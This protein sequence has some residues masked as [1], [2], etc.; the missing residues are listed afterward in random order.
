MSRVVK[1]TLN[2]LARRGEDLN[3]SE[4]ERQIKA[5]VENNNLELVEVNVKKSANSILEVII[6]NKDG[7]TLDDCSN[8]SREIDKNIT[9]DDY[10]Q[11]NY[12]IEV[13]SPGLDRNLKTDD[14]LRRNQDK[15]LELK[16]YSKVNGEKEFIG[17][18]K[19]YDN[20]KLIFIVEDE[21]IEIS[22][23]NISTLKQYIDFGGY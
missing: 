21:E 20:E 14:D 6:Y 23:D 16:L 18:I 10:F 11:N 9:L 7:I 22:R 19:N 3:K 13:A 12:N 5:I 4:L 8:I 2:F 15:D 1:A 17:K